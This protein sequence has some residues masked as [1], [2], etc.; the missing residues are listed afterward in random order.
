MR[1]VSLMMKNNNKQKGI[2][3]ISMIIAIIVIFI[4][5]GSITYSSISSFQMKNLES[6][7]S[8]LD[9]ISDSVSLY[10]I[11]NKSLPVYYSNYDFNGDPQEYDYFTIENIDDGTGNYLKFTE[12]NRNEKYISYGIIN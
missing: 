9:S 7:Y 4:I 12:D 8:D 2:T 6:L 10:W 5:L 11:K 3:L 1:G